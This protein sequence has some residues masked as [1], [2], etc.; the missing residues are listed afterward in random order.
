MK[1]WILFL[2]ALSLLCLTGC[3]QQEESR[4][5][6][7]YLRTSDTI[8]YGQEDALIAPVSRDI[9]GQDPGLDYLLQ[10]YLESP[11]PEGYHLPI[12]NGTYLLSTLWEEDTLVIVLSREFSTLDKMELT[13]AGAC[14][15]ATCHNIAGTE[16]IEV[17]SGDTVYEFDLQNFTFLDAS[18]EG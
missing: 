6:F 4:F 17:R 2:C 9:T 8:R 15:S 12:P 11:A 18:T 16:R 3:S 14:L 5:D 10:L 13:L 1:R 7:Y